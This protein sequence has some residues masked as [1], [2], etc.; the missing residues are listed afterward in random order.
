MSEIWDYLVKGIN[1]LMLFYE[2]FLIRLD[3]FITYT[4]RHGRNPSDGGSTLER[5]GRITDKLAKFLTNRTE[6]KDLVKK[7]IYKGN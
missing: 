4:G 2:I 1:M 5:K 6:K 3:N 7:G